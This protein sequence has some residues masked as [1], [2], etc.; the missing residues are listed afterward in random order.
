MIAI[1]DYGLG[2]LTSV[3]NAFAAVGARAE[4]TSDPEAIRQADGLVLPGVGAASAGME[5]LR[6]RGLDSVVLEVARAGRPVLGLCLGMQLLFEW[7]E[8]G[9]TACLALLGGSVRLLRGDHKVPHIGWNQVETRGG[10]LWEGLPPAPYF[11]FV[12]SYICIPTEPS[13]LAGE[14]EYGGR[15]CSAVV[16]G[17]IWGVQFH[18]ERSGNVGL[19]LIR[20]FARACAGTAQH[21]AMPQ[22]HA[23]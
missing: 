22:A 5:R 17:S 20:N 6:D 23:M 18:P 9:G 3:R 13:L 16:S 8:E 11:Y 7:S 1:V 19:Q 21:P 12:H 10:A 2:N 14:T 4:R 15:F